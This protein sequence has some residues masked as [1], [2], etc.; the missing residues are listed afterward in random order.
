MLSKRA[1][2]IYNEFKGPFLKIK[3]PLNIDHSCSIDI[4]LPVGFSSL[5]L[6]FFFFFFF[7]I[8]YLKKCSVWFTHSTADKNFLLRHPVPNGGIN[9]IDMSYNLPM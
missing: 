4:L 9:F 3:L 5:F 1:L 6:F 2:P 8:L 7:L